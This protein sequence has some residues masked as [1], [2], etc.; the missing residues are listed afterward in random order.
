M[1]AEIL[2]GQ[3]SEELVASPEDA[4]IKF[5]VLPCACF[6]CS[7]VSAI[8]AVSDTVFFTE[9]DSEREFSESPRFKPFCE[10]VSNLVSVTLRRFLQGYRDMKSWVFKALAGSCLMRLYG[11]LPP[12]ANISIVLEER[13]EK[14]VWDKDA[15]GTVLL[16]GAHATWTISGQLDKALVLSFTS[17]KSEALV[18]FVTTAEGNFNV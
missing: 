13:E 4:L 5:G 15:T 17:F 9:H 12:R 8:D 6:R 14:L 10:S 2:T 11:S 18:N 16:R 3:V 7:P 1:A